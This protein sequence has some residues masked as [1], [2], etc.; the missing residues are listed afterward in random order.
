MLR[1]EFVKLTFHFLRKRDGY[2]RWRASRTAPWLRKDPGYTMGCTV[3]GW[4]SEPV[5]RYCADRL[6]QEPI[7]K[8]LPRLQQ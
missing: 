1:Q 2:M 4:P 6:W 7:M 3:Q 5:G 8:R